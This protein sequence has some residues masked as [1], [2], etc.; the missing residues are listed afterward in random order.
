LWL[1]SPHLPKFFLKVE[2]CPSLVGH[3]GTTPMY[4]LHLFRVFQ[5]YTKSERCNKSVAHTYKWEA[6]HA[7]Q[8][9]NAPSTAACHC[10]AWFCFIWLSVSTSKSSMLCPYACIWTFTR[11]HHW[12][13]KLLHYTKN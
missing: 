2:H 4:A 3:L 9:K 6:K 11:P 8:Q 12:A 10:N 13:C 7:K 5:S 1:F